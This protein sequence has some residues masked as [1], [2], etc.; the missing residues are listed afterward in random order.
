M[1]SEKRKLYD[2]YKNTIEMIS[3][4]NYL[5]E[6]N[7]SQISFEDFRNKILVNGFESNLLNDINLFIKNEK[8]NDK[9]ILK[10]TNIYEH[11]FFYSIDKIGN[12]I[13]KRCFVI[14]IWT[15]KNIDKTL[16]ELLFRVIYQFSIDECVIISELPLNSAVSREILDKNLNCFVQFFL[17]NDLIYNPIDSIYGSSYTLLSIEESND[18]LKRNSLLSNQ[19]PCFCYDSPVPKYFGSKIGQIFEIRRKNFIPDLM[20]DEEIFYRIVSKKS[21]DTKK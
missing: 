21:S 2:V 18:F 12:K 16:K 15:E 19:L 5:V 6:E 9:I 7:D 14:Y 1:Y 4:R 20:V 10:C 11:S 13:K 3:N 17:N 8:I